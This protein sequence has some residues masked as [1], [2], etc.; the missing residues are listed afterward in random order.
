MKTKICTKCGEGLSATK[1]HFPPHKKTKDGF[2][3]WCRKCH[4][5]VTVDWQAENPEKHKKYQ[6]EYHKEHDKEYR[7]TLRGYVCQLLSYIK[8]RCNNPNYVGYKNYGGRGIKCGFTSN[9]LFDWVTINNIEPRGRDIH[10]INNNGNYT[11]DNI[12]F[13]DK[14]LHISLHRN[15]QEEK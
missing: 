8:T 1:K 13:M 6:K 10:R 15:M 11:L 7:K 9:E 3:S 14:G 12:T 2:C 5:T 4:N